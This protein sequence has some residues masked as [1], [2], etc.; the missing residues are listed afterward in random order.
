MPLVVLAAELSWCVA[1]PDASAQRSV[2]RHPAVRHRRRSRHYQGASHGVGRRSAS[3]RRRPPIRFRRPSPGCPAVRCP[4]PPVSGHP[5]SSSGVRRPT[6][7][8]PPSGVHP[9][10]VH[11]VRPNASGWSPTRRWRWGQAD[12]A[13][14]PPPRERVEVPA[15][16]RA[17]QR[18]GRQPSRPGRGRRRPGSRVVGRG[19]RWW[20]RVA[21]LGG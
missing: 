7:W 1:R 15:G 14:Q 4:A 3:S 10:G 13:R 19:C 21:F 16:C 5:G 9:S 17:V 6:V 11:P 20:T 8:C 18:P 2:Q 12:A